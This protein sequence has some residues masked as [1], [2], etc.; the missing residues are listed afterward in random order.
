MACPSGRTSAPPRRP[1]GSQLL[2]IHF[3][4]DFW[5]FPQYQPPT[6]R[7]VEHPFW[8]LLQGILLCKKTKPWVFPGKSAKFRWV[9]CHLPRYCSS[10]A[11]SWCTGLQW[12]RGKEPRHH[13]RGPLGSPG[14]P[15]FEVCHLLFVVSLQQRAPNPGNTKESSKGGSAWFLWW[16]PRPSDSEQALV[17]SFV[18]APTRSA[19]HCPKM[20]LLTYHPCT[21]PL[22]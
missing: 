18:Y 20:A 9:F 13:R 2:L 19:H 1:S 5:W 10:E 22:T 3:D 12:W 16:S 21:I 8:L 11:W 4:V 6:Y 15:G 7:Q 17:D 14:V